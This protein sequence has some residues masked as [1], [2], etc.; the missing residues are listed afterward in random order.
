MTLKQ[1]LTHLIRYSPDTKL[2]DAQ[3]G[4]HEWEPENLLSILKHDKNKLETDVHLFHGFDTEL[5]DGLYPV[6]DNRMQAPA[7]YTIR[8]QD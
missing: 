8:Y 7:L 5:P 6:V 3:E 2:I 1:A 4:M